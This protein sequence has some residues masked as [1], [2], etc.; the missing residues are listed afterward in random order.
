MGL[1]LSGQGVFDIF[2]MLFVELGRFWIHPRER[3]D[4][5]IIRILLLCLQE[6]CYWII[7]RI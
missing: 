4:H 5:V 1:E 6:Y 3:V 2:A 7:S